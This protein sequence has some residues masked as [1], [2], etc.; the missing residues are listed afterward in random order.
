M[1]VL[2]SITSARVEED[3]QYNALFVTEKIRTYIYN[4]EGIETPLATG[5]SS[6]LILTMSDPLK[7]PTIIETIEGSI[8]V[9]EGNGEPLKF[10]GQNIITSA[11]FT[12]VTEGEEGS[13]LRIALNMGIPAVRG[14][15]N[16]R[17]STAFYTTINLQ[18]P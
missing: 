8:F 13:T 11:E 15:I 5:T 1:N 6:R 14:G 18:H 10:S 9:Q 2:S 7:D 16:P 4:S 3:L 17:S 12:N